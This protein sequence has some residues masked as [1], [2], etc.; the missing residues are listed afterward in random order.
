MHFL[1]ILG[2]RRH[3]Q[4]ELPPGLTA[5]GTNP[6]HGNAFVRLDDELVAAWQLLLC[7]QPD[8]A[9][10]VQNLGELPVH[11]AGR[12]IGQNEDCLVT[13]P[14]HLRVGRTHLFAYQV[15]DAPVG[16]C[17]A[18]DDSSLLTSQWE[19]T[20]KDA[21]PVAAGVMHSLQELGQWTQA[22][23]TH[24]DLGA[25]EIRWPAPSPATLARWLES[26]MELQRHTASSPNF[27][28]EAVRAVVDAGGLDGSQLLTRCDGRWSVEASYVPHPP[29]GMVYDG[30]LVERAAATGRTV[31]QTYQADSASQDYH[32]IGFGFASPVFDENQQVVGVLY[33]SRQTSARNRR[34]GIRLLEALWTQVVAESVTAGVVRLK[35]ET[36]AA[37]RRVLLEQSFPASI[38]ARLE[39]QPGDTLHAEERE[40]SVLFVDLC[41]SSALSD[42]L[43]PSDTYELLADMMNLLTNAVEDHHGVVV[44]YYGDGLVAMW[45]APLDQPRHAEWACQA[46]LDMLEEL[47]TFNVRWSDRVGHAV[48][49]GVGIHTGQ[50]WVGNAGSRTR[51]KY[52]PRGLNVNIANRIEKATR[53][54]NVPLLISASTRRRLPPG[55]AVQRMGS[56][57][58]KGVSAPVMLFALHSVVRRAEDDDLQKRLD[59][60]EWALRL[61]EQN[62]FDESQVVLERLV[63]AN[64]TGL[65][66]GFLQERISAKTVQ[67][68]LSRRDAVAMPTLGS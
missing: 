39:R 23:E 46:A 29:A 18:P 34:K 37:R 45:N 26:L 35:H 49:L 33:A 62:R 64:T 32:S 6:P 59:E 13:F 2:P 15:V 38:V 11:V 25:K 20:S 16:V 43:G 7:R 65:S 68:E 19:S 50:V 21:P 54:L 31:Y 3:E 41:D 44:D 30:R 66:L 42:R 8:G 60:Y 61:L 51:I 9:L 57:Q 12:L 24:A 67:E 1:A 55:A 4:M 22:L 52:G 58:L 63:T 27:Y 10:R 5:V 56:V 28:E 40:V 17:E 14:C 47:K 53:S 36:D 48:K